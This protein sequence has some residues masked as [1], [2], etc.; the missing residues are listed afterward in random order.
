MFQ[1]NRPFVGTSTGIHTISEADLLATDTP[2]RETAAFGPMRIAAAKRAFTTRRVDFSIAARLIPA[3]V[4]RPGDLVLARVDTIG[5]HP[6]IEWPD[7]RRA[8]LYVGDEII[9]AYGGRHCNNH[10]LRPR[11][12]RSAQA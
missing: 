11:S 4:P 12:Q 9:V 1:D 5:Q 7:G 6:R 10:R 3:G 8:K 2:A